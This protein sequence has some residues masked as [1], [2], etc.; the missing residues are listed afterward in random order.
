MLFKCPFSAGG[1]D[2]RGESGEGV[3]KGYSRRYI[4]ECENKTLLSD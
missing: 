4:G 2:M 3:G 1:R